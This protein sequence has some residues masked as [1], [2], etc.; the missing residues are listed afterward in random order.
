MKKRRG[1]RKKEKRSF[2]FTLRKKYSPVIKGGN[3]ERSSIG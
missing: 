1:G 3:S 2:V